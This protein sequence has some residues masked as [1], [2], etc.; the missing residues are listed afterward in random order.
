MIPVLLA[1]FTGFLGRLHPLM[2][3]LPIGFLIF[4]VLLEWFDRDNKYDRLVING[5]F[6]SALSALVT[7]VFGWL[8]A[9]EGSYAE[10]TLF[11]HRWLGVS[12]TVCCVLGWI[13]K[14]NAASFKPTLHNA[15]NVLAF[16]LLL[17]GG[18]QGGN[19]TH[20]SDYLVEKAPAPLQS[21]LGYE[22]ESNERY[23]SL[24]NPDSVLIYGDIIQPIL[25]KK[26]MHCHNDE[27]ARG[28]LNMS[29][30]EL[31][32][33]GGDNG[34][35]VFAGNVGESELFRRLTLET[36]NPKYMPPK[37]TPMSYPEKR[38]IQWWLS[39]SEL[40]ETNVTQ[41]S[42]SEDV[43]T[44]LLNLFELDTEPRPYYE[45]AKVEAV[46]DSVIEEVVQ[47]GF[48][49]NTLA[50]NNNFLEISWPTG[51][52]TVTTESI[53]ALEAL[54]NNITWLNLGNAGV[55]DEHL[56]IIGNFPNLTRLR[57]ENNPISDQ[58]LTYLESLSHLESLILYGTPITDGAIPHLKKI[59]S[60]KRLYLWQT[61]VTEEGA[62]QLKEALPEL[63][64]DT[65]FQFATK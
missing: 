28:G 50:D 26:C 29:T 48:K 25:D 46:D 10:D 21:L 16:I 41:A 32:V 40:F 58:S 23:P 57:L 63:E 43:K 51:S 27:V 9:T 55:Q 6:L 3:H 14:R 60:L 37:G 8:L 39:Q 22:S 30:P 19:L 47:K 34:E 49:I 44:I 11:W 53:Q 20:G 2:V 36:D 15:F 18:H 45:T 5:W 54:Q 31:L 35:V 65:G 17:A 61:K 62:A 33:E 24:T 4:T 59:T 13:M 7:T 12:I 64:I 1:S 38:L 56:N 42:L 52:A